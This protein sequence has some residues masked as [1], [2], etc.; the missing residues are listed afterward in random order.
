MFK[1]FRQ[2]GNVYKE[3]KELKRDLIYVLFDF[4]FIGK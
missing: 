1:E 3:N 4:K 2:F